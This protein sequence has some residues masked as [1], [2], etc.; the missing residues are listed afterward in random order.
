M[1]SSFQ[2]IFYT[3]LFGVALAGPQ[4]LRARGKYLRCHLIKAVCTL[5]LALSRPK[6]KENQPTDPREE[7]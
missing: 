6:D 4:N 1:A 7:K 3:V 5:Y 2:I